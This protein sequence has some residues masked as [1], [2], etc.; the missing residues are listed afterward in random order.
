[1]DLNIY[2]KLYKKNLTQVE[3]QEANSNI[4]GFIRPRNQSS[5]TPG[6]PGETITVRES[7]RI[8]YSADFRYKIFK[9]S[10]GL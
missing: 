4:I 2:K 3:V 5:G 8:Q 9:N 6:T 7:H 1:M 10:L